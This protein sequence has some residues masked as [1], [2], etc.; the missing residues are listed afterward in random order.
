[1]GTKQEHGEFY[2]KTKNKARTHGE[3]GGA[4]MVAMGMVAHPYMVP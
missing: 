4:S 2:M 3:Y 1:M